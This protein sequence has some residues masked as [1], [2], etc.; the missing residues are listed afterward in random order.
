TKEQR[1]NARRRRAEL[2]HELAT[3][4]AN[5]DASITRLAQK[6][7]KSRQWV[8]MQLYS[9]KVQS[10]H[11]KS[12]YN[13][14]LHVKAL[15]RKAA[16][17]P[18]DGRQTLTNLSCETTADEWKEYSEEQQDQMMKQ[19]EE[20]RQQHD[21]VKMV[22]TKSAAMDVGNVGTR[23][24][25]PEL[26]A[27]HNR[28]GAE[29]LLLLLHGEPNDNWQTQVYASPKAAEAC[30]QVLKKTPAEIAVRIDGCIIGG[31]QGVYK[32]A[33]EKR[34]NTLKK[35]VRGI[36]TTRFKDI[37]VKKGFPKDQIPKNIMWSDYEGLQTKYG[38]KLEGW[39]EEGGVRNPG[40]FRGCAP[41]ERLL[42]ALDGPEPS[43]RWV[44][45]DKDEWD[46]LKADA[47]KKLLEGGKTKRTKKLSAKKGGRAPVS[48]EFVESS[49]EE[50]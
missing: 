17:I 33:G 19:L 39:T 15:E 5:Y 16:G 21:A 47:H 28:M 23:R 38:V 49:S 9:N 30:S 7:S 22:P 4:R 3:E 43:L 44:E 34:F 25:Q 20:A 2:M 27:L 31:V 14:I 35:G 45:L 8:A 29:Y 41:L 50:N 11:K 10:P 1:A 40:E 6:F 48:S 32:E 13:A 26:Q 12:V 42:A 36:M 46:E 37:L 24:L 18:S